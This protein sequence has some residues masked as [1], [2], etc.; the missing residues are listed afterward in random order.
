MG[1][2]RGAP[3]CWRSWV[4]GAPAHR[5]MSPACTTKAMSRLNPPNSVEPT[6]ERFYESLGMT[7]WPFLTDKDL[8]AIA[9]Q[10]LQLVGNATPSSRILLFRWHGPINR[11]HSCEDKSIG[12]RKDSYKHEQPHV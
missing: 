7:T 12:W 3:C 4:W 8:F 2:Q 10:L 1:P 11:C 5:A 9:N 6:C